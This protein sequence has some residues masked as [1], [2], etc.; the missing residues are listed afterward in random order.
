MKRTVTEANK[1][2]LHRLNRVAGQLQGIARMVEEGRPAADI[3]IQLKAVRSALSTVETR[4]IR[5][6]Y[7]DA[8]KKALSLQDRGAAERAL[9]DLLETQSPVP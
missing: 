7:R 2:H 8:V 6:H 3:L 1:D 5:G 4:L 9:L